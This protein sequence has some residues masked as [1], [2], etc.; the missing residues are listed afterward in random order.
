[1]VI[2]AD[3]SSDS[4]AIRDI[5]IEIRDYQ[6]DMIRQAEESIENQHRAIEGQVVALRRQ[7]FALTILVVIVLVACVLYIVGR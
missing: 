3:S 5:L 1:M 2:D 6:R 7:R 4:A